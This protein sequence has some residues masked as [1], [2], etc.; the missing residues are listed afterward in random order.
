MHNLRLDR[1]RLNLLHAAAADAYPAIERSA[2]LVEETERLINWLR[3][4]ES[5]L[6]GLRPPP[7][8]E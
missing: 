4:L 5:P 8:N 1:E 2:D 3:R 6:V 7:E